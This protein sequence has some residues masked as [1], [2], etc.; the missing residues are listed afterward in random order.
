ML[1]ALTLLNFG[2]DMCLENDQKGRIQ[3]NS[4]ADPG[5]GIRR[6][7]DTWFQDPG[8]EKNQDVQDEHPG[9]YFRGLRNNLFVLKYLNSLMRTWDSASL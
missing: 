6:L 8:C 9:S 2:S 1:F 5:S 3:T 4:V 7:L